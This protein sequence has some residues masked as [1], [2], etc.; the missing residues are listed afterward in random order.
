MLIIF[1]LYLGVHF[2]IK[3]RIILNNS[4]I[5]LSEIGEGEDALQCKTDHLDCCATSLNLFGEFYYPS[6]TK[7]DG[8]DHFYH[9]R[10]DQEIRLNRRKEIDSEV[11]IGKFRCEIPD[12]NGFRIYIFCYLRPSKIDY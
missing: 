10:G 1:L 4:I 9:T 6:E 8:G 12:A 11:P 5:F 2:T 7:V 3:G